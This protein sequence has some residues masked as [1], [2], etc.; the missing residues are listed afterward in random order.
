MKKLLDRI[1]IDGLGGM[2]QGL[3][4]TLIIGT[5]IQ[6]IGTFMGGSTGNMIFAVGKVAAAMTGAGIGV[7]VARKLD[8]SHLVIVSAAT[9]GMTGAFASKLLAGQVIQDGTMVFAGPGEPL[10]AFVAAYIAIEC[11]ILISGK[12]K[13]DIILTPLV[14]IGTGSAVGLLLGPPISR[15]M[16]WLGSLINWGTEQQPFLMGIIVSVLMGMI[17]TLP[18]SSAAL[19]IILNLSGLA[20][21][22]ATIGCCCN[23]VGFAVASFRENKIGGF[24]A[25][26][27]GTS[28][29]QVPNIVRKPIIW[30]P[31]ILSSAILGPVGTMVLHMTSNATGS[32]MGTAGLVGQIMTWQVMTQNEAQL[33]VL[34]KILVIQIL[35]PAFVTLGISEFMRKRKWIKFGD[36]KLEL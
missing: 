4:A 25:Q 32:G 22:A 28:M 21:G 16:N 34:I 24:L 15:F 2:A 35:L 13:L 6:Q 14:S 30:L 36:M 33:I 17:L 5:I 1:F 7:G 18:I 27:I 11:G 10:G 19:G 29:L 3:F 31:A 26:G 8:A 9:A 23:M 12:T 20:A